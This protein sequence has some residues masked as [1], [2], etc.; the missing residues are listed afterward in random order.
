[1]DAERILLEMGNGFLVMMVVLL[2]QT[3]VSMKDNDCH[4]K[5]KYVEGGRYGRP[6]KRKKDKTRKEEKA[7]ER[8]MGTVVGDPSTGDGRPPGPVG[9]SGHC[10]CFAPGYCCQGPRNGWEFFLTVIQRGSTPFAARSFP[11]AKRFRRDLGRLNY[12]N[13]FTHFGY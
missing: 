5:K 13:I 11:R 10:Q 6:R 8:A 4:K 1:M 3:L 2:T 12:Q 9:Q 7:R